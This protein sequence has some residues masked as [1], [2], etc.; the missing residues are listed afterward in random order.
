MT[1]VYPAYCKKCEIESHGKISLPGHRRKHWW[2]LKTECQRCHTIK[3]TPLKR[4][5]AGMVF[6]GFAFFVVFY[7]LWASLSVLWPLFMMPFIDYDTG[8]FTAA[9]LLIPGYWV[10]ARMVGKAIK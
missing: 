10:F 4:W 3:S 5:L 9:I 2:S 7:M 1:F 8:V 6:F